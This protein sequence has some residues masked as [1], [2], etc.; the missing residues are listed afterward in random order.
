MCEYPRNSPLNFLLF[1]LFLISF[2]EFVVSEPLYC[3]KV[4]F[5]RPTFSEFIECKNK[6]VPLFIIQN[7]ANKPSI[8]PYRPTSEYFLSANNEGSTCAE[9]TTIYLLNSSS[10]IDA[11]V[12]LSFENPGAFV[13]ILVFD[14]DRNI[15]VYS[16]RNDSSNGWYTIWG[17]IGT[18]IKNARV[19]HLLNN[20]FY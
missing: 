20:F 4:D 11:A 1:L 8:T 2:I 7:Y 18:T 9:S 10:R 19:R 14:A 5:N 15:P 16:W 13:E 6:F 12:F 17:R 3:S